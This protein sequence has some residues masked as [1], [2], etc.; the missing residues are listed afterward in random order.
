[1]KPLAENPG[2]SNTIKEWILE[3]KQEQHAKELVLLGSEIMI[4]LR[5]QKE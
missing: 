1:M 3:D 5:K 4:H 2:D